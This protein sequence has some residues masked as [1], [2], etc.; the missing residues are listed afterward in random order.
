MELMVLLD[1]LANKVPLELQ[2]TKGLPVPLVLMVLKETKVL[3]GM[4]DLLVMQALPVLKVLKV[5]QAPKVLPV[6]PGVAVLCLAL[7]LTLVL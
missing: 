2:A 4:Q 7:L 3:L 6:L 5:L 1:I